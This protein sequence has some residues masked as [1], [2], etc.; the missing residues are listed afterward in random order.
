MGNCF[1]SL[2][3]ADQRQAAA[4]NADIDRQLAQ[5]QMER[6]KTVKLLLLGIS[7]FSNETFMLT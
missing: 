3:S 7:T 5:S 2:S 4:R 1:G 6:D